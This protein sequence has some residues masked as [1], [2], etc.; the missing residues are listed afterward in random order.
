MVRGRDHP[1]GRVDGV[2]GARVELRIEEPRRVAQDRYR[3]GDAARDRA[4]VA[5]RLEERR[6]GQLIRLPE[7]RAAIEVR[8]ADA[9]RARPTPP[10]AP[11]RSR[12]SNASTLA[13]TGTTS[14]PLAREESGQRRHGQI[15]RRRIAGR[16][17]DEG[18]AHLR[19]QDYSRSPATSRKTMQSTPYVQA[20][21][22]RRHAAAAR[23][24]PGCGRP[25]RVREARQGAGGPPGCGRPV[26]EGSRHAAAENGERSSLPNFPAF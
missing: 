21:A 22:R 5:Q 24:A 6:I 20:H 8:A 17:I 19:A 25:A 13:S 23:H 15:G 1:Q 2:D 10:A 9:R 14:T 12:R 3:F 7:H 26:A 4:C 16:R 18:N 11:R